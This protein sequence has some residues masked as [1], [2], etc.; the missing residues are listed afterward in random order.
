MKKLAVTF[1]LAGTS[2][3]AARAGAVDLRSSEAL[4]AMT[5]HVLSQCSGTT[6]L[7]GIRSTSTSAEQAMQSGAQL[8]AP[9]SRMLAAPATCA[10]AT[11]SEAEGRVVALEGVLATTGAGNA[12]GGLAAAGTIAVTEHN[13]VPGLQC[14]DCLSDSYTLT[15]WRDALRI[16][17]AGME[18]GD[19]ALSDRDCNSDLRHSLAAQWQSLFAGG[20]SGGACSALRHAFRAAE[21]LG[22]TEVM[23]Q[24]LGLPE[25]GANGGASSF[26]N[27][28]QLADTWPSPYP[29][30]PRTAPYFP[31]FQDQDPVR[32]TCAG[33]NNSSVVAGSP[34][35]DLPA[36]QVCGA[37]G[38]LGLVL[39]IHAP[40]PS[41]DAPDPY[42]V[43]PCTRG[44]FIRSEAP[45]KPTGLPLNCPNGDIAIGVDPPRCW[46][47]VDV[48]GNANCL[49]GKNNVPIVINDPSVGSTNIDGRVYNQHLR[50]PNG[51]YQRMPRPSTGANPT[52]TNNAQIVGAFH[53]LHATRSLISP[54]SSDANSCRDTGNPAAQPAC[55]SKASDCSIA[56][57]DFSAGDTV[58]GVTQL[59]VDGV[60]PTLANVRAQVTAPATAYPLAT[61][62]Y[63]SSMVGFDSVSLDSLAQDKLADCFVQPM[64]DNAAT[65]SGLIPLGSAAVCEDF[66]ER[67]CGPL[68]NKNACKHGFNICPAFTAWA[69]SPT[70]TSVGG[71]INATSAAN[72]PSDPVT[73][74]WTRIVP[75]E[76]APGTTDGFANPNVANTTYTCSSAGSHTLRVTAYDG[77][78][79]VFKEFSISCL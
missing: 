6:T 49:N 52:I 47:P 48:V 74:L 13:G 59:S 46:A 35:A 56:T 22:S 8:I 72:D 11:P 14:T 20:C 5:Q 53:R 31:E 21:T 79:A 29:L 32:R 65:A 27:V 57:S 54:P 16:I 2:T 37:D 39:P 60:V 71:T 44:L 77:A 42:A 73:Y 36:E 63:L 15:D 30:L 64:L 18:H 41:V 9:M 24:I 66:D 61:R 68:L 62:L 34:P 33:T 51:S 26:C 1:A 43:N 12:C 28:R 19:V 69:V 38:T 70:T 40:V 23:L 58:A 25:A 10:H 75:G 76:P 17:Y 45:T 3:L 50:K 7:A 55:L 4:L 78:C 67:Q